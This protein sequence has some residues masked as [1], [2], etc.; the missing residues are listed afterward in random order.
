MGENSG[1]V[2]GGGAVA[3]IVVS[4]GYSVTTTDDSGRFALP[5]VGP[6]VFVTRP[7]GFGADPWFVATSTSEPEFTL[8]PETQ[9]VP[10]RFAHITDL[11]LSSPAPPG[12]S[13]VASSFLRLGGPDDLAG[14]LDATNADFVVATGDLTNQGIEPEY[15]ALAGVVARS[16]KRIHL[17][18]GNHDHM[19][20]LHDFVTTSEGALE[21]AADTAGY[22]ENIGP[23]W[24][25]FDYGGVHFVSIDWHT[26]TLGLDRQAQTAWLTADLAHVPADMPWILL[27]HDQP[28]QVLMDL[29]PRPPVATFS[30]HRHTDRTFVLNGVLHVNTPTVFFAGLDSS[31][32]THRIAQWDG[33]RVTTETVTGGH[34]HVHQPAY[35]ARERC[36]VVGSDG[37]VEAVDADTLD[38]RWTAPLDAPVRGRPVTVGSTVVA[39]TV[40]GDM[41]ALDASEGSLLWSLDSSDPLHRWT[42][43]DLCTD[44]TVVIAGDSTELICVDATS[45]ELRWRVADIASRTNIVARAA[46]VIVDDL[47]VGGFWPGNPPRFALGIEDGMEVWVLPP[48]GGSFADEFTGPSPHATPTFDPVTGLV[49]TTS[50]ARVDAADP[51]SGEA[52]W[53]T[54]LPTFFNLA[55]PVVTHAGIALTLPGRG[56]VM[57]DRSSGAERWRVDISGPAPFPMIPYERSPSSPVFA[58]PCVAGDALVLPGLDG[59]L[60]ILELHDG[61]CRTVIPVGVPVAAPPLEVDG[62]VFVRGTDSSLHVRSI[63]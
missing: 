47:V 21:N 29:L 19:N 24:Y 5:A 53:S 48:S 13:E 8:E 1:R 45:G 30:G 57:L 16:G 32:P 3:G 20:G 10:F 2:N 46:C 35:C 9:P 62:R 18:P 61:S 52:A 34:A 33:T 11:H 43:N 58:A 14:F 38:R 4:D 49:V 25:S 22:E 55:S 44:G 17:V 31:P 28:D 37:G 7:T 56:V 12:E 36:V 63:A 6:F 26:W 59:S 60:R 39:V 15:A 54:G 50:A 40:T 42:F 51:R 41:V 23:R 27:F